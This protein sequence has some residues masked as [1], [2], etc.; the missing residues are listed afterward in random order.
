MSDVREEE[1]VTSVESGHDD[2]IKWISAH[3]EQVRDILC[4]SS[5]FTGESFCAG[6]RGSEYERTFLWRGGAP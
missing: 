3:E 1:I 2:F 4:R 5:Q 6:R